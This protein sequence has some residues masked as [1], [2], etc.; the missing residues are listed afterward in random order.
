MLP[1]HQPAQFYS[2]DLVLSDYFLFIK[3][4]LQAKRFFD[5]DELKAVI[6]TGFQANESDVYTD[7]ISPYNLSG[8]SVLHCIFIY[9]LFI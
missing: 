1:L 8:T 5:D 4:F 7:G 6:C 9:S 3:K 2:Q